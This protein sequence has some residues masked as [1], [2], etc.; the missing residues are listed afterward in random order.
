MNILAI[1]HCPDTSKLQTRLA[2]LAQLDVKEL[3]ERIKQDEDTGRY[4][5]NMFKGVKYSDDGTQSIGLLEIYPHLFFGT[6]DEDGA[7]L[8]PP[9]LSIINQNEVIIEVLAHGVK[10]QENPFDS[11]DSD[12]I[13]KVRACHPETVTYTDENGDDVIVNQSVEF[14]RLA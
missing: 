11:L 10:Y 12:G 2:Q 8:S 5:V 4:L 1:T 9:L 14:V 13:A 3:S 7:L 6:F